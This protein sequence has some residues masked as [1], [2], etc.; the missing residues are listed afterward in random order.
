VSAPELPASPVVDGGG[1]APLALLAFTAGALAISSSGIL[2]RL[3]QTGP[4]ASAFWRGALALPGL[5]L[6]AALAGRWPSA[7]RDVPAR[8]P[9]PVWTWRFPQ[10]DPRFLWAG[11]FFAGDLGFWHESLVRTSVAAST[12]EANLAPIGV[13]LIAW[14]LWRERPSAGF[15]LAI[16]LALVGLL[17]I[18]SPKLHAGQRAL[19]GDLL[20][21]TTA[22]FYAAYIIVVARLRA[23]GHSAG[24]IMFWS[25]LI[26]TAVLLP[27]ALTQKMLPD[28]VYGWAVLLTL[29]LLPQLLG[30]GLIAYA[31][32]HLP[33]TLGAVVLYV[34][35]IAAALYAWL[36]L[37]ERLSAVQLAGA[38][39]VLCAIALAR[40]THGDA[41]G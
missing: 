6:W 19:T 10:W 22:G 30:Q 36:L 15:L 31:L 7:H 11:L 8:S 25:T 38:A 16:A 5:V 26:F 9:G 41:R 39:I 13:T 27:L 28:T 1:R 21:V 37:G 14:V 17:L 29:A 18:V 4:L 33:A 40:R 12:L 23:V 2:V 32:A 35:P 24:A 3:S 20:G 34:Q